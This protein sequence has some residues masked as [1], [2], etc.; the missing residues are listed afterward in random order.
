MTSSAREAGRAAPLTRGL[1]WFALANSLAVPIVLAA[2]P[3]H[4]GSRGMLGETYGL[5]LRL[6]QEGDS[7]GPMLQAFEYVER[8]VQPKNLYE[9]I[10]FTRH[11]KFQYPPTALLPLWLL[12]KTLPADRWE[13]ALSAASLAFLAA[14][15][16]ASAW[17]LNASLARRG[18]GGPAAWLLGIGLALAFYPLVK[19]YSLGQVQTWVNGLYALALACWVT[20]RERAAGALVG[21]MCLIKP[22]YVVFALWGVLRKRRDFVVSLLAVG[23]LG[24]AA[25]L[26]LFG[27]A[28]HLEYLDVVAFLSRRGEAYFP[29]Q[30]L[31]GL[32]NRALHNGNNLHWMGASFAPYHPLVF[33]CTSV[34]ALVLL[35]A[36]L[37]ARGVRSRGDGADFSMLALSVTLASPIAWE[38]H[39]G[40]LPPIY[41]AT[42]GGFAA[43]PVLGP[44]TLG[45]LALSYGL[46]S[47][48][49]GMTNLL[50]DTRWNPLQSYLYFGAL[51][52]LF[53][54][55]ALRA[56]AGVDADR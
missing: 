19:A 9:K 50:A 10:F 24:L 6:R 3:S 16:A 26:A 43:A 1:L 53:A 14:S 45:W 34:S 28:N 22:H 36:A 17:L 47:N 49:I 7:W 2:L 15:I 30:S 51:L 8:E 25:S 12:S 21:L 4:A 39:Y 20:S 56:R 33:W 54:L 37:Q 11:V 38:H 13:Q 41:A 32:L 5:L 52:L 31:N 29:N 35:L 18:E 48:Y 42:L 23:A 46:T 44:S 40:I 55:H 27:V